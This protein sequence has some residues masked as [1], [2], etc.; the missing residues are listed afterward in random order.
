MPLKHLELF[1]VFQTNDVILRDGFRDWHCGFRAGSGSIR[2]TLDRHERAMNFLDQ[3]RQ[4]RRRNPIMGGMGRDDLR[5]KGKD[6]IA[7]F[8]ICQD[9]LRNVENTQFFGEI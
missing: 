2:N 4:C 7:L 9:F 6:V 1:A 8:G 5:G 3:C